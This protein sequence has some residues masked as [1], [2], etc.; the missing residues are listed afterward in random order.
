MV[1]SSLSYPLKNYSFRHYYDIV[2]L[3]I[4]SPGTLAHNL[5]TQNQVAQR[6]L[7]KFFHSPAEISYSESRIIAII[8]YEILCFLS[9]AHV[10]I[11]AS[12]NVFKEFADDPF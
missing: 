3:A 1:C 5:I 10:H 4:D 12:L 2:I 9:D 6:D 11:I 7:N 8:Y